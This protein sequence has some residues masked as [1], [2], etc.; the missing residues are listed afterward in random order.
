MSAPLYFVA[1]GALREIAEGAEV[2]L[3]GA[4]GRH[5]ADV[6]RA[7]PGEEL[8]LADGTGLLA[9]AE[10][11]EVRRGELT[12]RVRDLRHTEPPDPRFVLV[13]AL[14]K[15]DRDHQAIETATELGVD[16]I[17]PWQADRSIVRWRGERAA[18]GH[19]KWQQTVFA[20]AKQSRRAILPTVAEAAGR[21]TVIERIVASAVALVLHES[22]E[23]PLVRTA[24]PDR[25]DIVLI[26]GPEG[27]ISPEE[28]AAFTRAGAR[29][30]RLGAQVLRTSTAGPAALSVLS[31]HERWS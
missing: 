13:Q 26:V 25:G 16:E 24:L 22:A 18:K 19:Q 7:R 17:V 2:R 14:A 10:V 1:G 30:V 21:E 20:A 15:G 5:A 4:E 3:D 27:G 11:S 12:A 31:A 8:L 6:A 29:P 28:L 23:A 9:R